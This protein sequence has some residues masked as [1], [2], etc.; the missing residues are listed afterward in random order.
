MPLQADFDTEFAGPVAWAKMY[1]ACGWQVVPA[2]LPRE[3]VN[4]KRPVVDWRQF[5]DALADDAT[6]RDW[7]GAA[8]RFVQR[9]NMG[10]IAGQC[11]GR[12]VVIDLDQRE[13]K[14]GLGWWAGLLAVHANNIE[15]ETPSQRTGGGGRQI[16]FRAPEGWTPPT[17]KTRIGVDI[18]GQGG[19]FVCPPSMHD[20]GHEY[21]WEPGR[22][23]WEVEV[24]DLPDWVREAVD[25]LREEFARNAGQGVERVH[26]PEQ[27]NDFG[28]VVDGREERMANIIWGVACDLKRELKDVEPAGHPRVEAERERAWGLYLYGIATR[29]DGLPLEEGLEREGR[30]RTAFMERWGRALAQWNGKLAWEASVAKPNAAPPKP[31]TPEGFNPWVKSPPPPFPMDTLPRG[32]QAYV[33]YEA[34][35]LGADAAG[36]AMAA[37]TAMSGALDQRFRVKMRKF[38][39]WYAPPRLWTMLVGESATKKSPIM[40]G[41]LRPLFRIQHGYAEQRARD[42]A[43]WEAT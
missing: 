10:V 12:L 23:P 41:A 28:Q 15:P 26:T 21:A 33:T 14:D 7:Y 39:D 38:G 16:V 22:A 3:H 5:E 17:F 35:N 4:W 1:R 32:Q 11:S 19:F 6:F 31:S 8:G 43:R 34:A 29:I 37:L 25:T 2:L 42:M 9:Q 36:V 18:R 20:S 13:G 30:G 40:Q 24:L 27:V